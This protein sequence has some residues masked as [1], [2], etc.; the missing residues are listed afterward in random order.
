MADARTPAQV[1]LRDQAE[2]SATQRLNVIVSRVAQNLTTQPRDRVVDDIAHQF[3]HHSPPLS[4][5]AVLAV[6]VVKLAEGKGGSPSTVV[7]G[8][9]DRG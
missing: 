8:G 3:A 9:G 4:V 7:D 1:A 2:A 5:A 6:A